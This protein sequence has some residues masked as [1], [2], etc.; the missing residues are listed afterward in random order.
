[1]EIENDQRTNCYDDEQFIS[2][3]SL[4]SDFEMKANTA[5]GNPTK[6]STNTDPQFQNSRKRK[7][8]EFSCS[9]GMPKHQLFFCYC[10]LV[11]YY[12]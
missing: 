1:M 6:I 5:S 11:H 7:M 3:A 12:T 8:L 9:P 10:S 2:E 4:S